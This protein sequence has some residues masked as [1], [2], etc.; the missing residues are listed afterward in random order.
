MYCLF[1]FR[2]TTKIMREITSLFS[3][4]AKLDVTKHKFARQFRDHMRFNTV[5]AFNELLKW[6]NCCPN[7][8]SIYEYIIELWEIVL[9]KCVFLN[10][11]PHICSH[12]HPRGG[13]VLPKKQHFGNGSKCAQT[14]ILQFTFYSTFGDM[15]S[16]VVCIIVEQRREIERERETKKSST[17]SSRT[18]L[19]K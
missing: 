4:P 11:I 9:S 13:K 10:S 12:L 8:R 17:V 14:T 5:E 15:Y 1:C 16:F 7:A 19:T 18:H 3:F 6:L 2:Q